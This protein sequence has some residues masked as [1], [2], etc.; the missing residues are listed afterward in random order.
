MTGVQTCA[1][2]ILIPLEDLEPEMYQIVRNMKVGEI[3]KAYRSTGENGKPVFRIIRLDNE[4]PAHRANL[5]DDFELFQTQ[6]LYAKQE[7]IYKEWIE[8]KFEITYIKV[9]EEFRQC[10]FTHKEWI[11]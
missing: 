1:L 6:A 7:K 8:K 10:N 5:K 11:K 4:R 9:S 3:S 2:P